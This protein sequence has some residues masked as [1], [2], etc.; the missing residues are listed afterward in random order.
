MNSGILLD[1]RR[2]TCLQYFSLYKRGAA[3]RDDA[4]LNHNEVAHA[5]FTDRPSVVSNELATIARVP[6][7][8]QEHTCTKF[9]GLVL[10]RKGVFQSKPT[11]RERKRNGI[12]FKC[13]SLCSCIAFKCLYSSACVESCCA[14]SISC[15][16]SL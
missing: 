9:Y 12:Y 13:S 8:A 1:S 3:K 16:F 10:E 5:V 6:R 14:S 2:K 15:S 11:K 4:V 7:F